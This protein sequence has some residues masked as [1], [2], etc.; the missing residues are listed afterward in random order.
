MKQTTCAPRRSSF[1]PIAEYKAQK[2]EGTSVR[3]IRNKNPFFHLGF[4][5][6]HYDFVKDS[7]AV[8]FCQIY[9]KGKNWQATHGGLYDSIFYPMAKAITNSK[10]KALRLNNSSDWR[11][12]WFIFPVVVVSGDIYYVDSTAASPV[13]ELRGHV[14]FKRQIQSEKLNG[15]FTVDFV[16]QDQIEAFVSDCLKP[17]ASKAADLANN[18]PNYVFRKEIPWED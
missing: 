5:E 6:L 18:Q 3:R 11:Y 13:P 10:Q 9:R 8:Q 7:K 16:R 2:R 15:I 17:L 14:T 12:F 1:I 4:S